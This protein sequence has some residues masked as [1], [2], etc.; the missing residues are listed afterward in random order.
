MFTAECGACVCSEVLCLRNC[1]RLNL[2]KIIYHIYNAWQKNI[3]HI[4][5]IP[6]CIVQY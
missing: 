4:L 2:K 1:H 5:N 3:L 6:H